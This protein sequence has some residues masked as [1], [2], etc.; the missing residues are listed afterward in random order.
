MT[1]NVLTEHQRIALLELQMIQMQ[2]KI[3]ELGKLLNGCE[4][5]HRP[6]DKMDIRL[7][8]GNR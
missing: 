4:N 1:E 8:G 7:L 6:A 5:A 2:R 3:Q